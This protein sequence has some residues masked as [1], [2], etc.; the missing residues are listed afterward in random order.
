[1]SPAMRKLTARA[2]EGLHFGLKAGTEPAFVESIGLRCLDNLRRDILVQ[3]YMP[4]G[5]AACI[6][7]GA[8]ILAEV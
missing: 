4:A 6:D 5:L 2:G 3:R 1:M 8:F 7:F